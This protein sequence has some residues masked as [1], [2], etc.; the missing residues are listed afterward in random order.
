MAKTLKKLS[1]AEMKELAEELVD[2]P[3]LKAKRRTRNADP[4]ARLEYMRNGIGPE[5]HTRYLLPNLG[6]AVTLVEKP[7][8]EQIDKDHDKRRDTSRLVEAIVE[9]LG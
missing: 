1:E 6:V 8:S 5:L 3:Y 2:L 7:G 9:P 4:D